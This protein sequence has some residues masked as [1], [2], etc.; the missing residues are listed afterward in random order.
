MA[1]YE[2]ELNP[3]VKNNGDHPLEFNKNKYNV[4][5]RVGILTIN[6]VGAGN[7]PSLKELQLNNSI[8]EKK[9][10]LVTTEEIDG[11]DTFEAE[12]VAR[13]T[14]CGASLKIVTIKEDKSTKLL[15]DKEL[16]I[17]SNPYPITIEFFL[18]IKNIDDASDAQ[19]VGFQFESN[20]TIGNFQLETKNTS[21][22]YTILETNGSSGLLPFFTTD[23]SDESENHINEVDT[24]L[25]LSFTIE[26]TSSEATIDLL[27]ASGANRAKVG[28]ARI[29]LTG[30]ERP[31][32]QGVTI[33]F[34]DGNGST[35]N[36]FRLRHSIVPSFIPFSLY[37]GETKVTNAAPIPWTDLVFGNSNFK[38]LHVGNIS[39]QNAIS[40]IAGTYADE[41]SITITPVDTNMVDQ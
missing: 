18:V 25:Y 14:Y 15:K 32:A 2:E 3:T 7:P 33:R 38:E 22:D 10:H 26:Q 17:C 35:T 19:G 23:Y 5:F 28:A 21:N 27:S 41:I 1:T 11:E 36:D 13:I 37:L 39:Y 24:T 31:S 9:I 29:T 6:A 30:Y 20:D 12:L 16:D 8:A 40:R 34:D 4:S